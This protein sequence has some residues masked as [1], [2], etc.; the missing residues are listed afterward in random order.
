MHARR[1]AFRY[2]QHKE[3]VK[4]LFDTV[5][6]AVGD[7]PGGY[8]RVIRTGV[9]KGDN[10]ETAIIELVDF[11]TDYSPKKEEKAGRTRRS[12]RR[13]GGNSGGN[14]AATADTA[15]ATE[16]TPEAAAAVDTATADLG[17]E[18]PEQ[19]TDT[20]QLAQVQE[21]T[22]EGDAEAPKEA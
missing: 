5:G 16:A 20:D 11:N 8:V 14:A 13:R 3:A 1:T 10:A 2:L 18:Q 12:R 19:V 4:E 15:V 17:T 9:R 6:P 21:T 7:R 22:P